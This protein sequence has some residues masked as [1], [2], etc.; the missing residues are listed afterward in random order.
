[1]LLHFKTEARPCVLENTQGN[2]QDLLKA[3]FYFVA[4]RLK[5]YEPVCNDSDSILQ[6]SDAII[7]TRHKGGSVLRIQTTLVECS[8]QS[9]E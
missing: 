8:T 3:K 4:H 9:V 6:P 5:R 7:D 1:M 2:F